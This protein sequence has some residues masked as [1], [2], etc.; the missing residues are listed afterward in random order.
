[1]AAN[2]LLHNVELKFPAF[3]CV[4]PVVQSRNIYESLDHFEDVPVEILCNIIESL[5]VK[6]LGSLSQVSSEF[7]NVALDSSLWKR[8]CIEHV[9]KEAPCKCCSGLINSTMHRKAPLYGWADVY[10]TAKQFNHSVRWGE[11]LGDQHESRLANIQFNEDRSTIKNLRGRW[12]SVQ[13]GAPIS[14]KGV[15]HYSFKVDAFSCNGMML[16]AVNSKW[17]GVYPG[18]GNAGVS[19]TAKSCAYYSHSSCIFKTGDIICMVVDLEKNVI[20]YHKNGE[21]VGVVDAPQR[22]TGE[23]IMIVGSFCG[24]YHQLSSIFSYAHPPNS[25]SSVH[26]V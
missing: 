10:K 1:M 20:T 11:V 9:E 24:T 13:L 6:D 3:G 8:H 15:Y 5:D 22:E 23:E 4:P 18:T 25:S 17:Q 12:V 14:G 16:G 21:H 2:Y 26:I 7:R 19:S